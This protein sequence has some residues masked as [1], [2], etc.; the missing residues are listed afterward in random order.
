LDAV[1]VRYIVDD[2]ARAI[3]FYTTHLGFE[4]QM[5]PGPGFAMVKRGDLRLLLNIPA[6]GGGAGEAMPDGTMPEPGG[7]NRFQL[8][9]EDLEAMVNRLR[10]AGAIFRNEIVTG[11]GG[12]QVL[13]EDPAGNLIELF[14]PF[15][16]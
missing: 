10:D 6:G 4:V 2:V 9:V 7:W 5:H 15:D 12:K 14:E 16:R 13:V 1:S 3:A 8:E 11:R